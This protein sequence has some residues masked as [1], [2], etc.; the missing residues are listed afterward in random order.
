MSRKGIS[1]VVSAAC[2]AAVAAL[3]ASCKDSAKTLDH[4]VIGNVVEER[5]LE[6][7]TDPVKVTK[8]EGNDKSERVE[9]YNRSDREQAYVLRVEATEMIA[10]GKATKMVPQRYTLTVRDSAAAPLWL[11]DQQI[12]P[13]TEVVFPM[14]NT[15]GTHLYP[16]NRAGTIEGKDLRVINPYEDPGLIKAGKEA[17]IEVEGQLER[18]LA[19]QQRREEAREFYNETRKKKE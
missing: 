4:F 19:M 12:F 11:L 1:Y 18:N 8:K 17:D 13:G 2:V 14:R 7:S 3:T 5:M 10:D 9:E 6:S 15:E 16:V